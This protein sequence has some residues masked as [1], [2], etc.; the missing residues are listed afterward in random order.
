MSKWRNFSEVANEG[1][2][3]TEDLKSLLKTADREIVKARYSL[4]KCLNKEN[5]HEVITT[6]GP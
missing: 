1:K 5:M 4:N 3:V 6:R 2:E